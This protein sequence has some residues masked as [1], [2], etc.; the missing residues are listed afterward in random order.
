VLLVP[1]VI[2]KEN[3]K[4]T[5]IADAF[6]SKEEISRAQYVEACKAAGIL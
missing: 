3:L 5:V 2:A 4:D 1:L 6:W